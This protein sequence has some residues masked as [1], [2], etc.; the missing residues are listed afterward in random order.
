[1]KNI[2]EFTSEFKEEA[3][4]LTNTSPYFIKEVAKIGEWVCSNGNVINITKELFEAVVNNFK[5]K[6]DKVPVP[7]GHKLNDVMANFGWV[8][9]LWQDGVSLF[10]KFDITDKECNEK[11]MEGTI[12]DDSVGL[13]IDNENVMN[14]YLEHIALTLTPAM[15]GLST[16]EPVAFTHPEAVQKSDETPYRMLNKTEVKTMAEETVSKVDFEK[17]S[18][19]LAE[20]QTKIVEFEKISADFETVKA[21]FAKAKEQLAEFDKVKAEL[22][23][24]KKAEAETVTK[25]LISEGKI[26][27][28]Q[29]NYAVA[30]LLSD[31]RADFE[32]FVSGNKVVVLTDVKPAE[33][34]VTIKEFS[35]AEIKAM[36]KKEYLEFKKMEGEGKAKIK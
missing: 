14:S 23:E 5:T 33:T 13:I 25:M 28:A 2:F 34:N 24:F 20:K 3:K 36:D 32:A 10:A 16:F 18:A 9:D 29:H 8:V 7:N 31:K 22:V 19:E 26:T 17:V 27:P 30:S 15:A 1:M 6:K 4:P 35:R 21:E 11:I 12:Q